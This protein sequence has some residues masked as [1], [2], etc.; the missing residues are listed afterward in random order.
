MTLR[1]SINHFHPLSTLQ[2]AEKDF[3]E[4]LALLP[5][6]YCRADL[7]SIIPSHLNVTQQNQLHGILQQYLDLFEG[8]L[9]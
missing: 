1:A 2:Q 6:E 7:R 3:E 9:G 4:K 5:A 8:K